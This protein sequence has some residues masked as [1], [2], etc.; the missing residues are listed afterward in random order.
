MQLDNLPL[1]V[2]LTLLIEHVAHEYKIPPHDLLKH[3]SLPSLLTLSEL[4]D[5]RKKF[6]ELSMEPE[7]IA[8]PKFIR[9]RANILT[10]LSKRYKANTTNLQGGNNEC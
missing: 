1:A 10:S 9:Y 7:D 4:A 2:Q 6:L 3:Y 5:Y 8:V